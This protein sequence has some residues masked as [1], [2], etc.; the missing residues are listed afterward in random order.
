MDGWMALYVFDVLSFLLTAWSMFIH[1]CRFS[2]PPSLILAPSLFF[3][4]FFFEGV[5]RPFAITFKY[6][7][8]HFLLFSSIF[9]TSLFVFF[10]RHSM[11]L[12]IFILCGPVY[13]PGIRDT[14]IDMSMGAPISFILFHFIPFFLLLCPHNPTQ[15]NVAK[16]VVCSIR[17]PVRKRQLFAMYVHTQTRPDQERHGP[18]KTAA[19]ALFF[20]CF[21]PP[22]DNYLSA[23]FSIYIVM[24]FTTATM[25]TAIANTTNNSY[26]RDAYSWLRVYPHVYNY[27]HVPIPDYGPP[28]NVSSEEWLERHGWRLHD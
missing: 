21:L 1:L 10:F 22:G 8:R 18:E 27:L 12:S 17:T 7:R 26:Q 14:F 2:F 20:F 5:R 3:F 24:S 15:P 28:A 4:F 19:L 9:E 16:S 11:S 25:T 6:I 23:Y 13:P